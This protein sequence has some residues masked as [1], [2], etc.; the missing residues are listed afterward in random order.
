M[1]RR[2]F[3]SIVN[4]AGERL[5]REDW[6]HH[7]ID[8]GAEFDG[9]RLR[10]YGN[11]E[12]ERRVAVN[13][14]VVCDLS[15]RGLLEVRGADAQTFLQGQFGNDLREVTERHSQLSSYCS[16][17]GRA[18]AVFRLFRDRDAWLIDLPADRSEALRKRLSMFV[19][20]AQVVIENAADSRIHFGVSGPNVTRHLET[21]LGTLPAAPGDCHRVGDLLVLRVPGMLHPRYEVYGELDACRGLWNDL[22]VHC[23]PFG[24][25]G[26]RLLEIIA[27]LP[28]VR[29]ATSEAFVPQML[30]LHALGGISFT[31]GCYPGQEVVARMH[32]L[33]KLKRRMYRLAIEGTDRPLPGSPVFLAGGDPGQPDGE[34]VDSALHPDGLWAAL[35]VLQTAAAEGPLRWGGPDGPAAHA[36]TLPYPVPE[37]A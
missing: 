18:Y 26:W 23:A 33:G 27:G 19:L 13:G 28:T 22:N 36:V 15:H 6:K 29:E 12:R 7:L 5:M 32:Y 11:G 20:R 9:D 17:K 3:R 34:I 25:E 2:K 31:K 1:V 35:A 16:P 21:A 37:G 8:H 4:L 14:D 24:P 30:N 10:D